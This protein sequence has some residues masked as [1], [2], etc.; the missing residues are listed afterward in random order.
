MSHA[1]RSW[2]LTLGLC[3]SLAVHAAGTLLLVSAPPLRAPEDDAREAGFFTTFTPRPPLDP[4]PPPELPEEAEAPKPPDPVEKPVA[5][6]SPTSEAETSLA[7]IGGDE[8]MP[9]AGPKSEVNQPALTMDP[10]PGPFGP[11]SIALHERSPGSESVPVPDAGSAQAFERSESESALRQEPPVA[12]PPPPETTIARAAESAA[13]PVGV[14][15]DVRAAP[16]A[17]APEAAPG[18]LDS[19]P[20]LQPQMSGVESERESGDRVV[21]SEDVLQ[22]A[23]EPAADVAPEAR[24]GSFEAPKPKLPP[25]DTSAPSSGQEPAALPGDTEGIVLE[26]PETIVA[27]DE[28]TDSQPLMEVDQGE[29]AGPPVP[30]E[31]LASDAPQP[32]SPQSS[33]PSGEGAGQLSDQESDAA[34]IDS[35][36]KVD[37][38]SKPLAA[39][40]VKIRTVRPRFTH[41]TSL[42]ARPLDP[43]I[44]LYFDRTGKV[45]KVEILR[46]SGYSD[47]DRPVVDAAYRWK[48]EGKP[49]S[50]LPEG[51]PAATL[52]VDFRILL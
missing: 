43:V 32:S 14:D 41:Y 35:A 51:E 26:A 46:S 31:L 48:A 49:L 5:L 18:T 3:V 25:D 11:P 10:P 21:P 44:R 7:W 39:K 19:Q 4:V 45:R 22:P 50:D 40:G 12:A 27:P 20:S 1:T 24:D 52:K 47:V 2:P 36:T 38:W 28:P 16:D 15:G 6:G 34:A 37:D 17:V 29:V 23:P 30:D 33:A 13:Q 9:H 8:E 42:T